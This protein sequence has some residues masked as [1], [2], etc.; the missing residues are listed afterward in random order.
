M[1]IKP[2]QSKPRTAHQARRASERWGERERATEQAHSEPHA[3]A[4]STAKP[5][6]D[7]SEPHARTDST[8]KP[9]ADPI[10]KPQPDSSDKLSESDGEVEDFVGDMETRDKQ[11]DK[12]RRHPSPGR[13]DTSSTETPEI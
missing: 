6:A 3:R 9:T 8:D 2:L 7:H 11:A 5:T 10:D 4:D 12:A 1:P 13:G